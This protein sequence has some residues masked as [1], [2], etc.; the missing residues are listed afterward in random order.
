[1][2]RVLRKPGHHHNH[3]HDHRVQAESLLLLGH[4][5]RVA[6]VC[7]P[8]NHALQVLQRL[9]ANQSQSA[10]AQVHASQPSRL[11]LAGVNLAAQV[12]VALERHVPATRHK[13]F[14]KFR[15]SR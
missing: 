13:R 8:K 7:D 15:S 3:G 12:A 5:L 10:R 1:M 14:V 9:R 2:S 6:A 4:A 11:S